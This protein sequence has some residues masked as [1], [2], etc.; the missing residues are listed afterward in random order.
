M[1]P[2]LAAER[3][4]EILAIAEHADNDRAVALVAV[5]DAWTRLHTALANAPK[6]IEPYPVTVNIDNATIKGVDPEKIAEDIAVAEGWPRLVKPEISVYRERAHL[7]A[8]LATIYLAVIVLGSDPEYPTWPVIYVDTPQGQL[9]WH[10]ARDDMDLFRHV[11][12]TTAEHGPKWDG[13]TT[14]EKYERL[15]A[16]TAA[17]ADEAA[18]GAGRMGGSLSFSDADPIMTCQCGAR[19][20]GDSINDALIAWGSHL[21]TVHRDEI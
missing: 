1:T 17:R 4:A 12:I 6:T 10:L 20:F 14:A 2:E 15:A 9:S 18:L 16:L 7:I 11:G 13:H 8:H 3:A 19:C 5:G 21:T